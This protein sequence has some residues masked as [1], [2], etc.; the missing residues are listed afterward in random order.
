M[1]TAFFDEL[2]IG[3]RIADWRWIGD[4]WEQ[5]ARV[6]WSSSQWT[7][8]EPEVV[9]V[10]GD[11][12]STMRCGC[13]GGEVTG[14]AR[15]MWRRGCAVGTRTMPEEVNRL[16]TDSVCDELL[17]PSPDRVENLLAE[18]HPSGRLHLVGT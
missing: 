2:G 8:A 11:V 1:S 5:T 10:D 4:P 14:S 9:V 13:G 7:R 18:G 3:G 16:L 12:N 17:A 6:S 15:P